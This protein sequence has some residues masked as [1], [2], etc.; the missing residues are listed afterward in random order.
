MSLQFSIKK[1]RTLALAAPAVIGLG[2]AV[3]KLV[4]KLSSRHN[5]QHSPKAA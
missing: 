5:R 2:L 4:A 1:R 3:W